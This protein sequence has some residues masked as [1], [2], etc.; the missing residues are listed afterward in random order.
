MIG[1]AAIGQEPLAGDELIADHD[2]KTSVRG[3]SVRRPD[4]RLCSARGSRTCS[5]ISGVA[6]DHSALVVFV[7]RCSG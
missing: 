7:F 5:Q 6:L 2:E 3:N 1:I 4:R